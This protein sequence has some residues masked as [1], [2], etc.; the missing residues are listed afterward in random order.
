MAADQRLLLL[1][2]AAGDTRAS[3]G[4]RRLSFYIGA[5]AFIGAVLWTIFTTPEYPP[6]NMEA[7]REMKERRRSAWRPTRR[8]FSRDLRNAGYDCASWA[9]QLFAWLGLFCMWLLFPVAVAHN[10]FGAHDPN[11]PRTKPEWNGVE[12]GFAA[13]SAVCFAFSFAL[14]GL[15]NIW[16]GSTVHNSSVC[17]AVL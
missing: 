10:V 16:E 11:C 15:A 13:Y 9:V 4:H 6:E 17:F 8:D 7:F 1:T 2:Q 14:P 3:T 12:S 5:A